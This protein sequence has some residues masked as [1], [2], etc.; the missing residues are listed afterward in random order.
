METVAAIGAV[1][2]RGGDRGRQ[3]DLDAILDRQLAGLD[4]IGDEANRWRSR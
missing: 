2:Q 3:R 1:D 4:H